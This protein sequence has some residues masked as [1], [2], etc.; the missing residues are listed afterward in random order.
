MN[1]NDQRF[2]AQKIRAQYMEKE[3]TKLDELRALDAKVKKPANVFGYVFGAIG[4]LVMGTGMSLC[5]DVIEPGTY[6]GITVGENMI[7]PGIVI[8]LAG[9]FMVAVNYSLYKGILNHRRKKFAP[10]ILELS[11]KLMQE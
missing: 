11:E 2:M 5:M 1:Q 3:N 4:A 6:F 10:R 8:G 9:I 7:L